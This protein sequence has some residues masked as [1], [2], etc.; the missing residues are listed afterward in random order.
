MVSPSFTIVAEYPLAGN[1]ATRLVHIDLY[2]TRSD[3]EV[4][5][6]GLEDVFT[7]DTVAIVEWADRA[8]WVLPSRSIRVSLTVTGPT[9]RSIRIERPGN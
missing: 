6:L 8:S 9:S 7:E 3:D 4:A 5:L 2:R 1:A